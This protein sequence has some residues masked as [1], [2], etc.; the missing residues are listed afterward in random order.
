MRWMTCSS[1]YAVRP[2]VVESGQESHVRNEVAVMK[3]ISHPFCIQLMSTFMDS[4]FFYMLLEL[5]NG[6]ELFH[7]LEAGPGGYRSPRH[8]VPFNSR[9]EGPKCVSM[10]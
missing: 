8:R 9:D 2:W 1:Q 6:G 4:R 7:H 3:R 5:T 10:K